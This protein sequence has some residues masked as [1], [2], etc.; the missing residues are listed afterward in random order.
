MTR[1]IDVND[2][3]VEWTNNTTPYLKKVFHAKNQLWSIRRYFNTNRK[4]EVRKHCKINIY[5][6]WCCYTNSYETTG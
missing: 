5:K 3:L 4:S 6:H 1:L 2:G